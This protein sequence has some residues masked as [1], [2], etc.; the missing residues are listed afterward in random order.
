MPSDWDLLHRAAGY[1]ARDDLR[2]YL[3]GCCAQ[4]ADGTLVFSRNAPAPHRLPEGHAERRIIR[5]A[6]FGACYYIAR[7]LRSGGLGLAKPCKRC[8]MALLSQK[9][10]KVVYSVSDKEYRVLQLI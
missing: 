7:L 5:K 1:A 2:E 3:V 8:H 9:A 4:R 6:G 10:S